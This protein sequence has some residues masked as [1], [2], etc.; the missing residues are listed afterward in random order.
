MRPR[1]VAIAVALEELAPADEGVDVL[2]GNDAAP[3]ENEN[4]SDGGGRVCIACGGDGRGHEGCEHAEIAELSAPSATARE[5][6]ARLRRA[7]TEHRAAARALRVVVLS[8]MAR[9]RAE[10]QLREI[11]AAPAAAAG[12]EPAPCA[13][14]AEREAG[15]DPGR[16]ARRKRRVEAGQQS[17]PFRGEPGHG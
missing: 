1:K 10:L 7:A 6:V 3:E 14:C 17:L 8:D 5:A 4:E 2:R 13:R 11:A 12:G 9:G 15:A 16:P